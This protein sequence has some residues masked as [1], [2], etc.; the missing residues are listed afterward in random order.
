MDIKA[1]F[2]VNYGMY[3]VSSHYN[4]K[5]NGQIVNTVFQVTSEPPKFAIC[6]N[7]KN[8][9]YEMIKKSK[10]FT[11]STLSRNATMK[12][13]GLFGFKSGRDINKFKDLKYKTGKTNAPIVLENSISYFEC[14]LESS[15]DA[16]THVIFI[17]KVIDA[18][19]ISEGEPMTYD[20]Y[21]KIIKGVTPKN[22]PTYLI[23]SKPK[24]KEE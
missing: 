16:G 2:T 22:A 19:I 20:Y 8:L 12:F 5:F 3:I 4:K 18:K 9:T 17:G 13:I 15:C 11:I 23:K 14:E 21:Y 7:K 10:V 6:I 1:F 24:K